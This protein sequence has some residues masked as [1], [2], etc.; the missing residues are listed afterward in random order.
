[1]NNVPSKTLFKLSSLCFYRVSI[2]RI[3]DTYEFKKTIFTIP[4]Y[5]YV[6][7]I[8]KSS[9]EKPEEVENVSEKSQIPSGTPVTRSSASRKAI[10]NRYSKLEA[11]PLRRSS[12]SATRK[13]DKGTRRLFVHKAKPEEKKEAKKETGANIVLSPEAPPKPPRAHQVEAKK[14]VQNA[15]AVEKTGKGL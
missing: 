4:Y 9:D 7:S 2:A 14:E 15:A 11:R 12:I 13:S 8:D 1:M 10:H 3:V 6:I 5:Y